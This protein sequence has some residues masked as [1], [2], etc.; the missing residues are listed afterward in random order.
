MT[1]HLAIDIGGTSIKL[2][3]IDE[4]WLVVDRAAFDTER[5][6]PFGAFCD[7]LVAEVSRLGAAA[8]SPTIGISAPGAHDLHGVVV[9]GGDNVPFLMAGSLPEFLAGRF[10]S[11]V[12]MENDGIC[13]TAAELLLG[14]GRGRDRFVTVTLGTGI[15]GSVVLGGRILAGRHAIPPE[16][17]ELCLDPTRTDLAGRIP[18]RLEQFGSAT[19]LIRLYRERQPDAPEDI[20]GGDVIDRAKAGDQAACEAVDEMTDK[21]GQAFGFMVNVMDLEA[22]VIGGGLSHAG[23]WLTA[24]ISHALTR[25]VHRFE[26]RGIAVVAAEAGNDAGMLGAVAFARGLMQGR[27]QRAEQPGDGGHGQR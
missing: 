5:E 22:V 23:A 7:Q 9:A 15:G 14:A 26:E 11:H 12:V 2:G 24:R 27:V 13:A 1:H 4:D 10:D 25:Y 17:G 16:F 19:A 18:G 21:L 6:A 3:L 8:D 20:S